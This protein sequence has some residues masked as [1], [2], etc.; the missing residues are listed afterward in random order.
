[1]A[2]TVGVHPVSWR[3]GTA[4]IFVEPFLRIRRLPGRNR[5][6]DVR[7]AKA[8]T[9]CTS[10]GIART[11]PR[12]RP[13]QVSHVLDHMATQGR[14]WKSP[15]PSAIPV[16]RQDANSR[17]TP[18]D[19]PPSDGSYPRRPAVAHLRPHQLMPAMKMQAMAVGAR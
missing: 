18:L 4:A 7:T 8:G 16:A 15:S 17:E 3:D 6:R 12:M 13:A 1:M 2:P 11:G 9:D 19:A 14:M 5:G 10:T